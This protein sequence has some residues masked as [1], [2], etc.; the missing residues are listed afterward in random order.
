MTTTQQAFFIGALISA[1]A[2]AAIASHKNRSTVVWALLGFLFGVIP[3]II[4][5][6]LPSRRTSY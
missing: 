5:A 4:C 1:V 6:V 2:C 3:V